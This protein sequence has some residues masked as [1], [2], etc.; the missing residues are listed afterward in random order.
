VSAAGETIAPSAFFSSCADAEVARVDR[1][2]RRAHL[3]RFASLDGGQGRLHLNVHPRA[4]AAD[5]AS[6]LGAELGAH[7]LAPARV[8]IEIIGAATGDEGLLAQAVAAC[9]AA[10][11][12]V[13]LDDFGIGRSNLDRVARLAPDLVKVDCPA[14]GQAMGGAQARRLLPLVVGLLREGGAQ[15]VVESIEEAPDALCAIEAGADFV[16]GWYFG[17][18]RSGL[19]PD[20][21][22]TEIIG[23]LKRLREAP[24]AVSDDGDEAPRRTIHG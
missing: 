16:Q 6:D 23:R 14:L 21:M 9:R 2:C 1:E 3:S 22:A 12:Q 17:G 10:G 19:A 13:A 7:G 8:C 24:T 4:L 5:S 11:V 20:P 18:A 15:V